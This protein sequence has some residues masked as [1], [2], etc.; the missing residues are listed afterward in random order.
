MN[1]TYEIETYV[2]E[3]PVDDKTGKELVMRIKT[4]IHNG[5]TFHTDS[6]GLH[7]QKRRLNYRETWN[8]TVH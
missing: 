8:L 7:M 6:S 4:D 2:T 1:D 3:L 5:D